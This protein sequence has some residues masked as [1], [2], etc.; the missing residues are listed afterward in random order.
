MAPEHL[1]LNGAEC[2]TGAGPE[3]RLL[4][5]NMMTRRHHQNILIKLVIF[6]NKLSSEKKIRLV[7]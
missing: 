6:D 3:M 2:K 4:R 5:N 1:P 7:I